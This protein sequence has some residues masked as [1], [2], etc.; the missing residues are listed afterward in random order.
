[1]LKQ[2][3][4]Q[5]VADAPN[6]GLCGTAAVACL[7]TPD[8]EK[9]TV[10]S[11]S[12]SPQHSDWNVSKSGLTTPSK[13][14]VPMT[15]DVPAPR[16]RCPLPAAEYSPTREPLNGRPAYSPAGMVP[17]PKADTWSVESALA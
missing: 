8:I 6:R 1:M 9:E 17:L 13:R 10:G 4:P 5:A 16:D 12:P 3:V 14:S 7:T 15:I 2:R 11:T